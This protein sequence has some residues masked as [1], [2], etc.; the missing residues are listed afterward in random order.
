MA[1]SEPIKGISPRAPG[2]RFWC[3]CCQKVVQPYLFFCNTDRN[4]NK[5]RLLYGCPNAKHGASNAH[6]R[7]YGKLLLAWVPPEEYDEMLRLK[8]RL[9]A[10]ECIHRK[11]RRRISSCRGSA[12]S[13]FAE[14]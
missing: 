3:G 8:I 2:K 14:L 10:E 4:D 12:K 9:I 13:T 11:D 6:G 5:D 7:A 1:N